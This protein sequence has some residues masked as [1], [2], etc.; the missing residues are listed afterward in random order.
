MLTHQFHDVFSGD[1]DIY[2][3]ST[4]IFAY[5]SREKPTSGELHETW[6]RFLFGQRSCCENLQKI[7]VLLYSKL[8]RWSATAN[9]T[10]CRTSAKFS[11]HI[12]HSRLLKKS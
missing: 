10:I 1:L 8:E 9:S 6:E 3:C 4:A 11:M 7:I 2:N 12:V 5:S